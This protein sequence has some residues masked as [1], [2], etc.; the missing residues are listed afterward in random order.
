MSRVMS[1]ANNQLEEGLEAF[2]CTKMWIDWSS[3]ERMSRVM[4]RA[5][6]KIQM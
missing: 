1:R 5:I 2:T 6:H 3:I 4:P